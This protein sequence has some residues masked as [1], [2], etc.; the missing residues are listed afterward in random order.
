MTIASTVNLA[1]SARVVFK[2]PA[3]MTRQ[4]EIDLPK[5]EFVEGGLEYLQ[6][7]GVLNIMGWLN[8]RRY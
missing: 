4:M 8:R 2:L 6:T 7:I 5:R 1:S 3:A